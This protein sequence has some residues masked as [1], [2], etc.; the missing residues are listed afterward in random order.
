MVVPEPAIEEQLHTV[1]STNTLLIKGL[2]AQYHNK[3]MLELYFSN[4]IK[5]RGGDIA[6]IV[7]VRDSSEAYITFIQPEG[8]TIAFYFYEVLNIFFTVAA[9]VAEKRQHNVLGY[10]VEVHLVNPEPWPATEEQ[11]HTVTST[12]TLLIKG[13]NAQYHSEVMLELYFSNQTK[14]GGGDIAGIIVQGTE[15]YLTYAEP[16]GNVVCS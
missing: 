2:N 9:R 16:G 4:E 8:I 12:N 11:L 13:L 6:E 14:C 7:I 3:A 5:C 15:A 10:E 1:T